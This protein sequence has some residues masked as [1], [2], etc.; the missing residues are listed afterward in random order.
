MHIHGKASF[1]RIVLGTLLSIRKARDSDSD[2]TLQMDTVYTLPDLNKNTLL[3]DLLQPV[4]MMNN[5][6]LFIK[7]I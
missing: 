7:N 3:P 1:Q 5:V 4:D 6:L 2:C